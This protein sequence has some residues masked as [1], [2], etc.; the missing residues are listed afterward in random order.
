MFTD[1]SNSKLYIFDS[2]AGSEVGTLFVDKQSSDTRGYIEV[3]PVHLSSAQFETALDVTWHGAVVTFDSEPIYP[4]SGHIGL[5][6]MV[7]YP[8]TVTVD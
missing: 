5:W 8:P 2:I 7:E 6:V 3:N 1:N 4:S